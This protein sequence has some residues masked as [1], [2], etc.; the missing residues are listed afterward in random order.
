M[1]GTDPDDRAID[2]A[3]L[4]HD[5]GHVLGHALGAIPAAGPAPLEPQLQTEVDALAETLGALAVALP[6]V[7]PPPSLRAR[8]LARASGPDRFAPFT[9]RLARMIDVAAD[10]A[11][12]LLASIDR[13]DVWQ[14]S[15]APNVKLVHLTGGPAVAGLDVGFVR[16]AAGTQFPLHRHIGDEHVLVLQGSYRDSAGPTVRAGELASMADDTAHDLTAGPERDLI[17]AVVFGAIEIGGARVD[18]FGPPG[19]TSS[20]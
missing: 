6:A 3:L 2:H 12:E 13:P 10:A 20:G 15:P 11:R 8:L 1:T 17:Y 19:S 14:P 18:A 7:D 4:G 9:D 5:L 16:V